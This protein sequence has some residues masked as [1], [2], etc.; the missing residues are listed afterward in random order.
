MTRRRLHELD[1]LRVIAILILLGFHTG[2]IF[3][4]WGW[5]IKSDDTSR[6]L[7][8]VM[9]WLHHWRMPLLLFIS[10][11][12]TYFALG[13]RTP[14]R[15]LA[16]R[17]RRLLVPLVFGMLVVVPPQIYYERITEFASFLDFYPTVYDFVPYPEG[18]SLSWHHLW[19]I[20]YLLVYS[21]IALPAFL[22][23]RGD[24]SRILFDRLV[25]LAQGRAGF[26][27]FLLPLLASQLILRPFYPH[28]THA[29]VGD[30]AFFTYYLLFFV[31]GFACVRDQRLWD[32]IRDRRRRHLGLAVASLVPFYCAWLVPY[33]TSFFG[34]DLLYWAP[35]MAMAWF[36]VLAAVGYGRVW[37]TR[38]TALLRYA[39]EAVYPFYILHQTVIIAIGY[40]VIQRWDGVWL[41]F[42]VINL[43]SF[44]GSMA[45]Y[46]FL[47]RP[48][49]LLRPL[50][51]VK[52][53]PT[54]RTEAAPSAMLRPVIQWATTNVHRNRR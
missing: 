11:A 47:I 13:F 42:L 38:E 15:F 49:A 20:L 18:G 37:L 25:R 52:L 24:R 50:F 8:L 12:G 34:F 48:S 29:L 28:Q 6:V 14:G 41:N 44:V 54:A 35:A 9:G 39:N 10:G 23:L 46:H 32:L 45:I 43:L 5:H 17:H 40:H 26:A 51:G 27:W 7:E 31:V 3:V 33:S 4:S 19:F 36:W 2:M 53:R 22:F 30:W 21:I 16:E 1:W